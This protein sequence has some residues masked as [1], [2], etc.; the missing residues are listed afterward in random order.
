MFQIQH[1]DN[2]IVGASDTKNEEVRKKFKNKKQLK[3]NYRGCAL[4]LVTNV[5]D[6]GTTINL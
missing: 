5:R 3:Q 1:S 2:F 4:T 6:N